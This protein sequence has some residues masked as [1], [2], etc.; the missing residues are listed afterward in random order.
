L[1]QEVEAITAFDERGEGLVR[2]LIDG[3]CEDILARLTEEERAKGL[4][5]RRGDRLLIEEVD[6]HKNTCRVSRA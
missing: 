1:L 5:V 2:M 3:R 6:P 4:R